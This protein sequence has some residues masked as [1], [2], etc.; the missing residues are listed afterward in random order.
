MSPILLSAETHTLPSGVAPFPGAET[1]TGGRICD[2]QTMNAK[3]TASTVGYSVGALTIPGYELPWE[4]TPSGRGLLTI[5]IDAS[6]GASDQVRRAGDHG[7]HA[8]LR[9]AHPERRAPRV[10]EADAVLGRRGPAGRPA[11]A[12]G[13]AREGHA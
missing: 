3:V 4:E 9:A 7:L 2:V 5:E 10:P 13:A 11:S 1:G 12:Q 8:L 6:N